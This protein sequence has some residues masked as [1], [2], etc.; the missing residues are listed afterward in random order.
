MVV[1]DQQ[2]FSVFQLRARDHGSAS[3]VDLGAR[4][5]FCRVNLKTFS[6]FMTRLSG[7]FLVCDI[8]TLVPDNCRHQ[9][10]L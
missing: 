7:L 2:L 1:Q 4:I 9:Q 10:V 3:L 6:F 5:K 8:H